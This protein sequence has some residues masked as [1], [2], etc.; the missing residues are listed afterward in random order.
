MEEV[1]DGSVFRMG[2]EE[3]EEERVF[4]MGR[5]EEEDKGGR[6]GRGISVGLELG[7]GTWIIKT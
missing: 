2:R 7:P 3:E 1:E 4:K 6:R 5:E